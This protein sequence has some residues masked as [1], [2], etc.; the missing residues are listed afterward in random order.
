MTSTIPETAPRLRLQSALPSPVLLDGGWW[1]RSASPEQELPGLV[2]A[3]TTRYG[4]ITYL[5]LAAARWS[6]QPRNIDVDGRRVRLGYFTSQPAE[7]LTAI[8]GRDKRV[9]LLIVPPA[10]SERDAGNAMNTAASPGNHIQAADILSALSARRNDAA[11]ARENTWETEGGHLR[12]ER[13]S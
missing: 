9:D 6:G 12:D 8:Y 3:L 5:I 7:L 4:P 10:S 2:R 11:S 1:P 13:A